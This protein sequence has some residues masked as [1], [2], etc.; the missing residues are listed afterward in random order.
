MTQ[1]TKE[2]AL[3]IAQRHN[4][5]KELNAQQ[6]TDTLPSNCGIYNVPKNCWY[7]FSSYE[8]SR[9]MLCSSRL[10]CICRLTGKIMYDGSAHD[11]G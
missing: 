11:E 2:D 9:H 7:V 5:G 10:I 6:I 1:I 8:H 3:K 4:D